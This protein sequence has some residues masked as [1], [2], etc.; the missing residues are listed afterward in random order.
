MKDAISLI[1]KSIKEEDDIQK[2]K[3]LLIEV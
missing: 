3:L 2:K 1:S